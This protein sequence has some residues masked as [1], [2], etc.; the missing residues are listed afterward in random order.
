MRHRTHALPG[1]RACATALAA[2]GALCVAP[3]VAAAQP[4]SFQIKSSVPSG[5]KP[6][7]TLSAVEKVA[8]I[9]ITL[10]RDDGASFEIKHAGLAPGGVVSLPIGDGAPGK[11]RYTGRL[12]LT[13]VGSDPWSYDLTFETVVRADMT[14][15]Y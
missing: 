11:A 2:L 5:S 12:A 7:I 4:V 10:R 3:R 1:L 14:L 6:S 15:K 13:V 8:D 9:R